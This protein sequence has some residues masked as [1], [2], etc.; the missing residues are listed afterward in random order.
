MLHACTMDYDPLADL[1]EVAAE[2][3]EETGKPSKANA[4][5][6]LQKVLRADPSLRKELQKR[7]AAVLREMRDV[8]NTISKRNNTNTPSEGN[9]DALPQL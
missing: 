5:R 6:N 2:S 7:M 8:R 3:C 9:S 4:L 1:L